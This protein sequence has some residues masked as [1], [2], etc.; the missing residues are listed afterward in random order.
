MDEEPRT[1]DGYDIEF[2]EQARSA[3]LEL[4]TRLGDLLDEIVIVGGL[5]PALLAEQDPPPFDLGAHAGTIDVDLGLDVTL[6]DD[7]RYQAL[8]TRLVEA[9]FEPDL[10]NEDQPMLQRWRT[11]DAPV[12]KIDFLINPSP[13]AGPEE[14][15]MRFDRDFRAFLIPGLALAF[16][17][18]RTIELSGRTLRGEQ[19]T[20]K[21]HVCGPGA[22]TV[23]K[24]LAFA[25]RGVEKDAY[26]LYYVWDGIGIKEVAACLRPLR[27]SEVVERSLA[28]IERDF[29]DLE[30]IGPMR[31]AWF[32]N[33]PG[34]ENVLA[35]VAGLARRLL[36]E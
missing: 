4:A 27:G 21:F 3:C 5:A 32:M 20:R 13:E 16:K 28:Y 36:L 7:R 10:N 8:R 2:I 14:R 11:V 6:F 34:D 23:L 26:D 9:G 31:A 35:D 15:M 18:R 1:A 12:V 19:A 22:F 17:D 30:S 25:N 33:R 29:C 24:A